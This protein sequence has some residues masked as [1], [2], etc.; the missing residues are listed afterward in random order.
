MLG[1]ADMALAKPGPP[2][3]STTPGLPVILAQPSAMCMAAA[4]CLV[5][6]NLIPSSAHASTRGR[7]VSPTMVKMVSTPSSLRER[8]ST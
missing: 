6:T 7:M 8:R 5:S 3:T 4:S 1:R 2:V